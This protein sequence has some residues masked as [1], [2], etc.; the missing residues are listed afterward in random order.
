MIKIHN[1]KMGF[2]KNMNKVYTY[3]FF[4]Y[5]NSTK[6]TLKYLLFNSME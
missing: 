5:V 6:N 4:N 1:F 3:N 2:K